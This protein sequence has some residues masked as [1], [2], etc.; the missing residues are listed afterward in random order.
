MATLYICQFVGQGGGLGASAIRAKP[1]F[2]LDSALTRWPEGI[3]GQI[4]EVYYRSSFISYMKR[5][6]RGGMDDLKEMSVS[7]DYSSIEHLLSQY[8]KLSERKVH[9]VLRLWVEKTSGTALI[10]FP[11]RRQ[12]AQATLVFALEMMK[13]A[14][15]SGDSL[16]EI[17]VGESR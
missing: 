4:L 10:T 6:I 12:N 1:L 9:C 11:D 5:A 8:K 7:A 15:R 16:V 17:Q 2:G 14:F 3:I 13:C